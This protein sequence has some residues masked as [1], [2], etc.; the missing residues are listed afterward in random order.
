M[1]LVTKAMEAKMPK[2]YSTENIPQEE[3]QIF[4]KFFMPDGNFTWYAIEGQKEENGDITFF[5]LVDSVHDRE[6]GYFTLSQLQQARGALRL[7]V[8]RDLHFDN[9]NIRLGDII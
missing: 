7:P 9:K 4:A 5:G 6:L 3:K 8:E 2:L 1:K